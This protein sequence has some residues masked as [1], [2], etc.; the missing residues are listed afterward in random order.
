MD[1]VGLVVGAGA[2]KNSWNPV[3]RAIQKHF[4]FP[5]NDD[6]ANCFLTRLVYLLRWYASTG[7]DKEL[8]EHKAFLAAVRED[9]C[10]EL[11]EA[12]RKNEIVVR[13]AFHQIIDRFLVPRSCAFMLLTTNWDTVVETALYGHLT[14]EHRVSV[15]PLHIHG[16]VKKHSTLYLPSEVT[17]EPYRTPEED[18]EIGSIH[19]T[20]WRAL[21]EAR[22]VI[23]YGLSVS[24]L[25]AE[26]AQTLAAGLSND[27]LEQIDVIV[28]DHAIVAH[29][30]NLLLNQE[31]PIKVIGYDPKAL[32][33]PIDY[34]IKR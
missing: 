15:N 1:K 19:G 34:T 29:R 22:W 5:L 33:S 2:V 6:G 17:R 32:H 3:V 20:A 28:P 30:I 8:R 12:E 27:V 11:V 9:I 13:N 16:S 18:R 4:D 24:P 26:L 14:R 31:R 10:R 21:E 23:V 25:D 7:N